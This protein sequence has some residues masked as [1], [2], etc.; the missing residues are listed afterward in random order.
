MKLFPVWVGMVLVL[1]GSLVAVSVSEAGGG[2]HYNCSS[3]APVSK[4]TG[5]TT[6]VSVTDNC[7]GPVVTRVAPGDEV[8]WVNR[9][10]QIH[11]VAD[12]T[13]GNISPKTLPAGSSMTLTF[14]E[15]GA[16]IY[17]CSIHPGMMGAVLVGDVAAD[18][19]DPDLVGATSR[20]MP[21]LPGAPA[22]TALAEP[23]G[24]KHSGLGASALI[25]LALVVGIS[26]GG[27]T[28]LLMRR[29]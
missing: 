28:A 17:Y 26:S 18:D 20:V 5:N 9:G 12:A 22:V 29:R 25:V 1:L 21:A 24:S 16:F 7:F 4:T 11:N 15:A 3:S 13:N 2:G 6:E 8:Q 19:I 23:G 10:G 27:S 14:A